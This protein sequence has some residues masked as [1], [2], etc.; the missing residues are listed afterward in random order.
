IGVG[1]AWWRLSQ[2]PVE[3]AFLKQQ[4]QTDLSRA[5]GGRP[6]G[7][8][9]VE[10]AWTQAGALELRAVNVTAQDGRGHGLARARGAR[11]ELGRL[12][13]LIGHVSVVRAEFDG[14]EIT[15]TRKATG[16]TWL[17]FGPPGNPPD[18]IIPPSPPGQTLEE[19]VAHML[20]GLQNAFAPVGS[21]GGLK[22]LGI[23][24]AHLTIVEEA[25][26]ARWTA[27]AA[28]FALARRGDALTLTT[29]ARLEGP[30]GLAPASL[31]IATDT[32]FQSATVRF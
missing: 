17:A 5:R 7:I 11:V 20:D 9:G 31:T 12:P 2:G 25:N 8:E 32:R 19:S 13:L 1:I 14:G 15:V 3:L 23:R 6:V 22:G 24:D 4:I 10:L 26:G 29:N 27:N 16:A 21:A 30:Q 28:S 18:I